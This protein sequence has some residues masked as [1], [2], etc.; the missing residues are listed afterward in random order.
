VRFWSF[1]SPGD[2]SWHGILS[3]GI[4]GAGIVVQLFALFRSLDLRDDEE[5]R[6]KATVRYFF[7]G[8]TIVVVGV[9]V[10]IVVAA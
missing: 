9:I 2:W 4:L 1:E 7:W 5:V 8:I 6:Y 3:A 10:A